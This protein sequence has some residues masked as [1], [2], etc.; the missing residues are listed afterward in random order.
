MSRPVL[1]ADQKAY[2]I[3]ELMLWAITNEKVNSA[4]TPKANLFELMR[5]IVNDSRAPM[6]GS[7]G[8][9]FI[10]QLRQ[11][12]ELWEKVRPFLRNSQDYCVNRIVGGHTN[13]CGHSHE[14]H[15]NGT[16][17]R[18]FSHW[19]PNPNAPANTSHWDRS[20]ASGSYVTTPCPCTC[21]KTNQKW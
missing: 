17:I 13:K 4:D 21:Y 8:Q 3:Y 1:N 12:G 6:R 7:S 18:T 15:V 19:V 16:C 5:T 9:L 20:I 14:D 10:Q 2:L 11:S